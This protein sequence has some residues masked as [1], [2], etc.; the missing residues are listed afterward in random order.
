MVT[1]MKTY[2]SRVLITIATIGLK[3]VADYSFKTKMLQFL[4][5]KHSQEMI[6]IPHEK[7]G[8]VTTIYKETAKTMPNLSLRK[9]LVRCLTICAR[10]LC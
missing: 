7:Y 9:L 6:F 1:E 8:N 3:H 4:N 2:W 5:N 10:V